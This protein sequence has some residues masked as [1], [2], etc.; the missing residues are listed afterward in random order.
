MLEPISNLLTHY[1]NRV[2]ASVSSHPKG[3][4]VS[5]AIMPCPLKVK[6]EAL[7]QKLIQPIVVAGDVKEVTAQLSGLEE[8]LNA[9]LNNEDLDASVNAF[10]QNVANAKAS[11]KAPTAATA[12]S[13]EKASTKSGDVTNTPPAIDLPESSNPLS[14]FLA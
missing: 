2:N 11:Q 13:E 3:I 9:A 10:N 1:A 6:D 7:R 8:T 12:K 14:D 5:I 4:Q